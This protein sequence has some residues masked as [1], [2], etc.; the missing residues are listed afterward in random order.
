M[1]QPLLEPNQDVDALLEEAGLDLRQVTWGYQALF[2][3]AI[4]ELQRSDLIG[5]ANQRV[6]ST[7]F[8]TL[9]RSNRSAVDSVLKAFLEALKGE[10]RW[11]MRLPRLFARWSR[12]G[13]ALSELRHFLGIKFFELSGQGQLGTTP[14]EV[15]FVLDTL[16]LLRDCENELVGPFMDGY[17]LLAGCLDAGGM[18]A[19]VHES[20]RLFRRNAQTGR[21]YLAVELDSARR[22]LE[23]MTRH[24]S[25][26]E[27]REA[28]QRLAL[29]VLGRDVTIGHLGALDADELQARGCVFVGCPV[30]MYLPETIREFATRQ[31]NEAC[32]K[33]MVTIG[34]V[35]Q[36]A[37]G[38]AASHG[39]EGHESCLAVI[40]GG[41][42]NGLL[43]MT[44]WHMVEVRRILDYCRRRFPGTRSWVNR[45]VDLE[46]GRL[47]AA[48]V[49][50]ALFEHVLRA[51]HAALP[52]ALRELATR[53][54]DA[55]HGSWDC[56]S[57]LRRVQ[58]LIRDRE[59]A[60]SEA[61]RLELP[62][63]LFFFPD[64]FFPLTMSNAPLG[65]P[66]LDMRDA[67]RSGLED[68]RAAGD[69]EQGSDMSS[70]DDAMGDARG[71]ADE[72]PEE[73]ALVGYFYDEWNVHCSDYHRNWCCVHERRP[74]ARSTVP[75]LPA[76]LMS[77]ADQ[78]RRVF[79]RLR[80][81]EVRDES[82]LLEGDSIDLDAFVEY[83]SQRD[84][85]HDTDMR[86]YHKPL[87]KRRDVAV[88]VLLDLSGSTAE[89]CSARPAQA[90]SPGLASA[91]GTERDKTVI[92]T[93]KEA[94]FVLAAGLSVL[95]DTFGVFGFTGTGRENCLFYVIKDFPE[96]WDAD[97]ARGLM[98]VSPGS[99]TR[100]GVA[101]R[102]A[103]WKLQRQPAK[104][105]VLLLITDGKPCDQGYDTASNYAQHDVRRACQ[106]NLADGMHT[107]C[108]STA[109]N[110]P[111]DM[112]VMFPRGRYL[113][114]DDI[115]RL[116]AAISRLYL[117][118]TR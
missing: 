65:R 111:A 104:T 18:R 27:Q 33:A 99:S 71:E 5:G 46:F 2:R 64:P 106:E 95:G 42:E 92:D 56:V 32:L 100:I 8:E 28:L 55:A 109:E 113:V 20:V 72:A 93:E 39:T 9:K 4:S 26:S 31:E 35:C 73:G 101:L 51:P 82:R 97:V 108:I 60:P 90:G 45:L 41:G 58:Q 62:R 117:R 116:P 16:D 25:L 74:E 78:I 13:L 102:H 61:S 44:L 81:D 103:G 110:T 83:V 43:L 30:A 115:A 53:L 36:G 76:G 54:R 6:T 1:G 87:V 48:T 3:D 86:F 98:A 118:L 52:A 88:A 63:P 112:A 22:R 14:A 114:L 70:V 17:P 68:D 66:L 105:K 38:F 29:A 94:A 80:P 49:T 85:K 47:P 67:I 11:L 37:D 79:E 59:I 75:V 91:P 40:G 96:A 107:F 69:D 24:A 84:T 15:E 89:T 19:F 34:A 50:D 77:Y 57:S 10:Y 12:T 23:Q 21:R 7:F